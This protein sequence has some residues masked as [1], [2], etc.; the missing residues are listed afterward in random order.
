MLRGGLVSRW[1]LKK[2]LVGQALFDSRPSTFTMCSSRA[3]SKNFV[4][5]YLVKISNQFQEGSHY[6]LGKGT[7]NPGAVMESGETK[8]VRLEDALYVPRLRVNLFSTGLY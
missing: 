2:S 5:T 1:E 3:I 7:I 8:I 6:R 4:M